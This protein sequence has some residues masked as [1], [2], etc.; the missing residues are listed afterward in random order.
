MKI[1]KTP[2]HHA[3]DKM[4]IRSG[5]GFLKP[6]DIEMRARSG[7]K[8]EMTGILASLHIIL[9]HPMV[10]HRGISRS[11]GIFFISSGFFLSFSDLSF[12]AESCMI[13][14]FKVKNGNSKNST[15]HWTHRN[16]AI[17][18]ACRNKNTSNN[19]KFCFRNRRVWRDKSTEPCRWISPK[20]DNKSNQCFEGQQWRGKKFATCRWWWIRWAWRLCCC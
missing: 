16:F 1:S 5:D 19:V 6:G 14:M 18:Q 12:L 2:T 7:S 20:C 9:Q 13:K 17:H 8:A 15:M 10:I 4:S 3:R 11:L